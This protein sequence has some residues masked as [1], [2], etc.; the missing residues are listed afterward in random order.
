MT[1]GTE[2]MNTDRALH[3]VDWDFSHAPVNNGIH[4]IH[5]YPAKFIPEIPRHLIELFHPSDSS[6]VLDPFCGSGTTLVEAMN[7]GLD[8]WGID[9][10]PLACLIARVKTT[11]VPVSLVAGTARRIITMAR[12]QMSKNTVNVPHIPRLDHWFKPSAQ[13][14]WWYPEIIPVGAP[15]RATTPSQTRYDRLTLLL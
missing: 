10:N 2:M 7:M 11:P 14:A 15:G 6:V 3:T 5:P 9:I 13:K 1:H 8:T 12:E 4:A